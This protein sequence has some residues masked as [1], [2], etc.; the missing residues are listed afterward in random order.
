MRRGGGGRLGSPERAAAPLGRVAYACLPVASGFPGR[1]APFK[2]RALKGA[3]PARQQLGAAPF[4]QHAEIKLPL[5]AGEIDP[6]LQ[7]EQVGDGG[8]PALLDLQ[9]ALL[10]PCLRN[11]SPGRC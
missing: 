7:P 3:T 9:L 8:S 4:V 1:E 6:A 11:R 2:G 10:S 5:V